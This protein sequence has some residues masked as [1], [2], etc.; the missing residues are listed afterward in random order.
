MIDISLLSSHYDVRR[1]NDSDADDILSL[2]KEN[3]Q[4]Y[5]Y[6]E[7]QATKEQALDDMHVTPPGIDVSDKYYVGFYQEEELIAVMDL[8]DGYPEKG[9]AWIGFFMMDKNHQGKELGSAIIS[10]TVSY[11]KSIG[12]HAI[13]LGIDK[14]NPQSTHFW[15]KNDFKIIKE[16]PR[17]EWA[18]LVAE[19]KL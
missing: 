17:G 16:V 10:E 19:R 13:R 5:L 6:C 4:F 2:C 12:M 3:A 7:A 14:G 18:I 1:L 15:K 8:I 9:I 11:L